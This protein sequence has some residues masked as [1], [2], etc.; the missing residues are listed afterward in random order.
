MGRK[1]TMDEMVDYFVRAGELVPGAFEV[2]FSTVYEKKHKGFPG[3]FLIVRKSDSC[4]RC[5]KYRRPV[6]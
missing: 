5:L 1:V 6:G 3:G 4:V 2:Q